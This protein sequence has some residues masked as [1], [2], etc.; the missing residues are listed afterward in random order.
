MLRPAVGED[1]AGRAVRLLLL[2]REM[3]LQVEAD[4]W[5]VAILEAIAVCSKQLLEAE[6]RKKWGDLR[7]AII[8]GDMEYVSHAVRTTMLTAKKMRCRR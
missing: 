1:D 6:T 4:A 5:S 8:D 3:F 2:L 7:N